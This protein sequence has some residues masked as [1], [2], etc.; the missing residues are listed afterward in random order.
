ME[1]KIKENKIIDIQKLSQDHLRV[2]S[3]NIDA[4]CE[5]EDFRIS[6]YQRIKI[7][8]ELI[9]DSFNELEVMDILQSRI[10]EKL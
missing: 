1:S 2:L 10:E 3:N 7:M 9:E 6:N 5:K 8:S 4:I